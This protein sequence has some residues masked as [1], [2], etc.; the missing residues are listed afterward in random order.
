MN[1]DAAI[2]ASGETP[3]SPVPAGARCATHPERSA[4]IV[5]AR[6]GSFACEGCEVMLDGERFCT[7]CLDR[8][9]PLADPGR[10]LAAYLVDALLGGVP[11]L[12]LVFGVI[13]SSNT[14]ATI[15]G[16][17]G[18]AGL[19]FV[20]AVNARWV[21]R[22][23]QSIGKRWLKLRVVHSDG[24]RMS[25]SRILFARNVL[26]ALL[27][28]IPI[29][30]SVFGLLDPLFVFSKDRRTLHDRLADSIVISVRERGNPR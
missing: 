23:G 14:T 30:G 15:L 28:G 27:G 8:I 25:L 11:V 18:G 16:V 9:S 6:C 3:A 10:R 7:G 26:P 17:I 22:H 19:L 5:C 12:V 20:L 2:S 29:V 13:A 24:R 21:Q 1:E 4:A